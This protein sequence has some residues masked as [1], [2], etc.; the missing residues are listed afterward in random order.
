MLLNWHL[1]WGGCKG[2]ECTCEISEQFPYA[3]DK[4]AD[5]QR[6]K[7]PDKKPFKLPFG[8]IN[9]L[10]DNALRG[11]KLQLALET[12][13][14]LEFG[15]WQQDGKIVLWSI[16]NR[17]S[18]LFMR[19]NLCWKGTHQSLL[20]VFIQN[21]IKQSLQCLQ[22]QRTKIHQCTICFQS[23]CTESWD[24]PIVHSSNAAHDTMN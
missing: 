14:C 4:L 11:F 24:D 21:K 8:C 3:K 15:A 12:I 20:V 18:L 22:M 16:L 10:M 7:N 6:R 23:C 5:A 1:H 13:S 19:Y 17:V 2:F 9:T